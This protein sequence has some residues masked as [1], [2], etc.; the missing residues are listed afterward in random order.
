[1]VS[2]AALE[3]LS[4]FLFLLHLAKEA[5]A[6]AMTCRLSGTSMWSGRGSVTE[7]AHILACLMESDSVFQNGQD[8]LILINA[9][10]TKLC[11]TWL[12]IWPMS[13]WSRG[14]V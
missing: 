2:M 4:D 8:K 13:L 7:Y 3:G 9:S 12:P 6:M 1:M 14:L 5:E 11:K 10:E